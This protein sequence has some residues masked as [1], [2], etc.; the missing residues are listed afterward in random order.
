MCQFGTVGNVYVKTLDCG[1]STCATSTN[2][3]PPTSNPTSPQTERAQIQASIA[4]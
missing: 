1:K 4:S 2:Y 3:V